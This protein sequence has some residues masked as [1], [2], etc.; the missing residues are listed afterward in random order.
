MAIYPLGECEFTFTPK[1]GEEIKVDRTLKE[2]DCNLTVTEETQKIEMD[3][4]D[5]PFENRYT[6]STVIFKC[7]VLMDNEQYSK[8]SNTLTKGRTGYAYSTRGKSVQQGKLVIHPLAAG[9][10][11]DSDITTTKAFLKSSLEFNFKKDGLHKVT[12]EFE[13][14][15]DEQSSSPT[16]G[17]MFTIGANYAAMAMLT[18]TSTHEN[19]GTVIKT[20]E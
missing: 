11:K 3:Q 8:L 1:N 5:G 14:A 9:T 6:G 20:K 18:E 12:L 10:S 13:F 4:L 2:E 19:S 7:S 17:T 15:A 16:F